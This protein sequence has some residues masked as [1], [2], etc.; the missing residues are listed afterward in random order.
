VVVR[1]ELVPPRYR[2]AVIEEPSNRIVMRL[3]EIP[4]PAVNTIAEQLARLLPTLRVA[5]AVRDSV[6]TVADILRRNASS[7]TARPRRARKG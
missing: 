4:A 2:L 5:A 7:T 6:R 3:P 1:A